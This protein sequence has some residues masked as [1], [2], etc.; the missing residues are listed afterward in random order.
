MTKPD[1]IQNADSAH[2]EGLQQALD[3]TKLFLTIDGAAIAFLLSS[4][5]IKLIANDGMRWE[6]T[7]ALACF[8][9]SAVGGMLVLMEGATKFYRAHYSLS[10]RWAQVP[11]LVNFFG[12]LMGFVAVT[13]F[14]IQIVWQSPKAVEVRL[15]RT[16]P[17]GSKSIVH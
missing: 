15:D 16:V 9:L 1:G 17:N 3:F 4:D 7:V 11:G 6:V 2:K 5:Q 10:D 8:G 12:L 13:L 14:V